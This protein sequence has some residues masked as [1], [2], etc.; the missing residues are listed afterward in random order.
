MDD[1]SDWPTR[2]D[3]VRS[4]TPL[5]AFVARSGSNMGLVQICFKLSCKR[6]FGRN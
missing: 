6:N 2:S 4:F 3:R 5:F 1:V